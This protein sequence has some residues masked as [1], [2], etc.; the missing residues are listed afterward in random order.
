MEEFNKE[1]YEIP[2]DE[3]TT[4]PYVDLLNIYLVYY[5]TLF[6]KS[7]NY[8]LFSDIN[9]QDDFSTNDIMEKLYEEIYKYKQAQNQSKQF[10][11]LY[12]PEEYKKLYL[13][14]PNS[15]IPEDHPLYM[16]Y[17]GKDQY[18]SHNLIT[19]LVHLTGIDWHN[20][21]WSINQINDL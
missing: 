5:K 12:K 19:V 21:D 1:D 17:D 8:N 2:K 3:E 9:H 11:D 18:L 13:S 20:I 4:Q 16:V 7:Q 10:I 6:N 15:K 14:E